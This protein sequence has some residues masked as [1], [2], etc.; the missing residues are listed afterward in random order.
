MGANNIKLE[1]TFCFFGGH[2]IIVSSHNM[3][4]VQFKLSVLF[5]A[6]ALKL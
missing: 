2:N 1:G 6:F 5:D 4:N 3:H